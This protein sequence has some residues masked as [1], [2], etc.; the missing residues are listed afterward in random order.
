MLDIIYSTQKKN[1]IKF[2][3]KFNKNL[4]IVNFQ[5]LTEKTFSE[6]NIIEK[7]LN[8]K[9]SKF[10]KIEIKKQNGNRKYIESLRLKRKN[11]ILRSIQN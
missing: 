4:L 3:K 8:I 9:K 1:Y 6:I 5:K 2:K 7:F 10:T 11:E